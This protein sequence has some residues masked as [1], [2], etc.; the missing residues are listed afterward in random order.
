MSFRLR[1]LLTAGVVLGLTALA[2]SAAWANS[3]TVNVLGYPGEWRWVIMAAIAVVEG[4]VIWRLAHFPPI[5]ALAAAVAANA[6]STVAGL[7][8]HLA[9]PDPAGTLIFGLV[10]V[11]PNVM[12]EYPA[13]LFVA[14]LFRRAAWHAR[15]PENWRTGAL[16]A[17]LVMNLVSAPIIP[18]FQAAL[19][20]RRMV[21]SQ[22]LCLSNVK[23][24]GLGVLSY[25]QQYGQW[26]AAHDMGEL[27]PL[28]LPLVRNPYA[29]KCPGGPVGKYLPVPS[30]DEPYVSVDFTRLPD[31]LPDPALTP[32]LWDSGPWHS[33]W[34]NVVYFDGHA[35]WQKAPGPAP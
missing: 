24:V 17:V 19:P 10:A 16:L 13:V 25:R 33:G 34:Y 32:M 3:G 5:A 22:N 29:L 20:N 7:W 30:G 23:Q 31:P 35:K 2:G 18:A 8:M 12:L 15:P 4:V 26:P 27:G 1:R 9:P 6:L 11:I 28:I 14:W 21:G